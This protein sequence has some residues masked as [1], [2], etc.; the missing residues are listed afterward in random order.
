MAGLFDLVSVDDLC[1]KLEHDYQ[2]VKEN[3]SDVFSAFDFV[4]TAW[5]LLE[6]RHP[7][8]EGKNQRRTLLEHNPILAVCEH[9]CVSG[10][11]YAPSDPRI[12]AVGASFRS[13][14]WARGAWAPGSWAKGVWRDELLIDLSGPAADAF[15]ERLT[16]DRLADLVMEFWRGPGGCSANT[17]SSGSTTG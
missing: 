8:N 13:S 14:A 3:A 10:K 2:R 16:M 12:D 4:V 1:G 17:L 9:L 15:G 6:W 7:G 5:H 11:H